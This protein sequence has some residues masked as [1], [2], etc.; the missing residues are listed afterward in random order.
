[1]KK[2]AFHALYFLVAAWFGV[3]SA[4]EPKSQYGGFSSDP[5]SLQP[6][7]N[8]IHGQEM[9]KVEAGAE[10]RRAIEAIPVDLGTA[11]D[12]E[13]EAGLRNWLYDLLVAFSASGNDSLAAAFYLRE[14]FNNPDL[15]AQMK[16]EAER[17]GILIGDTGTPFVLCKRLHREVALNFLAERDYFFANVSFFDSV[18]KVFEMQGEYNS[19]ESYLETHGMI[20]RGIDFFNLIKMREEVEE[21]LQEGT[22]LVFVDVMFIV[23]E[24]EQFSTFEVPGRTPSFF[25]LAWD[26]EEAI[27]RHVEIYFSQGVP[28]DFL[29]NIM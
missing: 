13:Q 23:E 15:A 9:M 6:F 21:R 27:W 2:L 5:D 19:Y 29:F 3:S 1:M 28:Q 8:Y 18:F 16:K 12:L 7:Y 11:I 24:P 14:G 10:L 22:Q 20:P 25:R 4:A 17:R 26:S